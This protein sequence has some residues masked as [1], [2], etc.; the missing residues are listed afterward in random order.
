MSEMP[1]PRHLTLPPEPLSVRLARKHVNSVLT[2]S[3]HAEWVDDAELAVTEV[4]A[5]VVLH[6]RTPCELLV[7]V[8]PDH[9]RVS[10]RDF[11]HD[12]PS[13]KHFSEYATTGRGLS[14]VTRLC[15]DFGIEPVR[16]EG[17]VTGKVIWFVLDGVER[18]ADPQG[19][20]EEWDLT[21]LEL[22]E[23]QPP[24][25]RVARLERMPMRLFV[26]GLEHQAAVLRELYLVTAGPSRA[27]TDL[28]VDLAAAE[29]V[30]RSLTEGG[31]LALEH[32]AVEPA[33]ATRL[34]GRRTA[35]KNTAGRQEVLSGMP[36]VLDVEVDTTHLEP[37]HVN[38]FQEALD[39]GR[40]L[41]REGQLLVRPSLEELVA[42]RG[43][44]CDQIVAQASGID[45][46][47]WDGA[48]TKAPAHSPT[49]VYRLR[50]WDDTEI[51]TSSRCVVAADDSNRLIAVSDAAA[52][53]LG[54]FAPDL[55]GR[56]ITTIIPQRL[57]EQHVA[58]FTRHLATGEVRM[59][60]RQM[61]LPILRLDGREIVRRVLIE[62][63]PAPPG[64]HVYVAWFDE[65]P[66]D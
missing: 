31:A 9:V 14:L 57:R 50:G 43:W 44:V 17:G 51:R 30:L 62:Q 36:A 46:T 54:G 21:G 65:L 27:S 39:L 22:L 60:G 59:L 4:V 23:E 1:L 3:D 5:N 52:Q 28:P 7:E 61:D 20:S 10:V 49:T 8:A 12:L 58:G 24:A 25:Q 64:R 32:S 19:L 63:A 29:S 2:D 38:A 40:R 53:M 15:A 26:A 55:L 45:P 33:Q 48:R 6:A 35:G 34:N 56:R 11:S 47:P 37:G 18:E 16:D 41:A 42:L 13:P 66:T